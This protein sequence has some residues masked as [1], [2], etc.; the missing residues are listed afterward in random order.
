MKIRL[1]F[2]ILLT[3]SLSSHSQNKLTDSLVSVLSKTGDASEQLILLNE[4]SNAYKTTSGTNVILYGE[5]ALALSRKLN[6]KLQQG[7]AY[8]NLGNGNIILG[9]YEKAIEYFNKSKTILE[10]ELK[11]R[12]SEDLKT[13]LARAYGSIG[14]VSSE[15]SNY[16]RAFEYYIKSISIYEELDDVQML[17]K[18]Y[19]NVG[20]A[21]KSQEDYSKALYYLKKAKAIQEQLDDPNI[22]ITLTNIANCYVKLKEY[23]KALAVFKEAEPKVQKNPRALGEWNNSIG[24]Y[25]KLVNDDEKANTHWDDAVKAF[26]SIDDKFGIADTYIFKSSLFFEQQNYDQALSNAEMALKLS[27]ETNVLEQQVLA[28]ALLSKVY[29]QQNNVVEA[30]SHYKQF[31]KLNDSLANAENIRKGVQAEMN[32]EY[33]KKEN[34]ERLER[35]KQELLQAEES[36]Q[37][38]LEYGFVAIITVLILGLGFLYYNRKQLKHRLTLE[39]ELAEYEQKALH[40][41]MNPHFIFNCLGAISGFIINNGTDHAIKYLSK[42]SKL[43][44][45]TLEYSKES[46]I[47][48][49]KEIESLQNYL[50]LEKLRFNDAFEF[51]ITK[52][53]A[54]EDA[55]AIPPLL[56]QPLVENAII[57]G[58]VPKKEKAD[59]SI[60][61]ST[62][63]DIIICE[64]VDDGI[65]IDTSNALKENS[66]QIHKSMALDIIRKRLKMITKVAHK[67]ASLK[68]VEIKDDN[69]YSLGTRVIISLP[70]Q[71]I[72]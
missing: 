49:G 48:I 57:H 41:Q 13:S 33:Q 25:Y 7:I 61:F 54:I 9:N 32:F 65:G 35:E 59:I 52:S 64:I 69:G 60:S 29:E 14:V 43:M 70:I 36:K 2:I 53:D 12:P 18:L 34:T 22:G 27:K 28:E 10:D 21:Y 58:I 23:P 20:V 50:E 51:T 56:I 4:I 67:K 11:K 39:K 68:S 45:L 40:L 37:R 66:V 71:Y 55:V 17:S 6:N 42:F 72:D 47:P 8:I 26:I 16:S 38:T 24:Y 46:L 62:D 5:K 30:L 15:Q 1:L 63:E 31:T 44:R 19:N 3:L